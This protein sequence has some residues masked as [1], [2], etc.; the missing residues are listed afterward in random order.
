MPIAELLRPALHAAWGYPDREETI[1]RWLLDRTP[2]EWARLD[3]Q[4]RSWRVEPATPPSDSRTTLAAGWRSFSRSGHAREAGVRALATDPHPAALGFLLLRCDDWVEAV[5]TIARAAVLTRAAQG[6]VDLPVWLPLLLA[7]SARTRADG[8]VDACTGSAPREVLRALLLHHDRPTRRWA[9]SRLL[10]HDPDAE[11]L[12]RLLAEVTDPLIARALADRLVASIDDAGL[13]RLLLDRRAG[14]RRRAWELVARGRLP[15]LEL[16][17]G[18][19]D[20]ASS[21][22]GQAQRVARIRQVDAGVVYLAMPSRRGDERRRRLVCLGEWGAPEAIT[23]AQEALADPDPAVRACAVDVLASRLAAPGALLL[24]LLV[25]CHGVELRAVERGLS[26]HRVRVGDEALGALRAGDVEQR[27]AAWR[28]GRERGRWE[29]VL[30]DL[31]AVDD[32]DEGL[33]AA[34]RTDLAVWC[35]QVGPNA[36]RPP[37][38]LREALRVANGSVRDGY[39]AFVLRD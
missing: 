30:A 37:A 34:A 25:S 36:G 28:L 3:E 5:R 31:L 4:E 21:I 10:D 26:R 39:L 17:G 11:E 1:L 6:R 15:G 23:V 29:R 9:L 27:R 24:G 7:R 22:R 32:P 14:V 20:R 16:C 8:L 33:A 35:R 18:L 38:H 2:A 19:L 12:T 13:H